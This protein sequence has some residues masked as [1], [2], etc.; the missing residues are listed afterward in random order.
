MMRISRSRFLSSLLSCSL[1]TCLTSFA[2]DPAPP[3]SIT[4]PKKES[5]HLY[6]LIGQSNMAGRGVVEAVDKKPHE[7]V[8]MFT[9]EQKWAPALDPLHFDKP[10]AGVGLGSTFGRVMA[11]AN[12]GVT[13]GLVPCA[14]GG[15]PLERWQQDKDLYKAALVRIKAAMKD[16]TLKGI[17]WHQGESD[18][19]DLEK[20]KTYAT[21]LAAMVE[22]WRKD[23]DAPNVPF[24]AGELGDFLAE[25]SKDGKPVHWKL[26]NEQIAQIPTLVKNAAVVDSSGLKHKGDVVHFDSASLRELGKRYAKAMQ[27]LQ[28][29]RSK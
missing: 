5:L 19:G 21:R 9:K 14:V 26:V 23:L 13:I 10:I 8:V 28:A 1:L 27:E 12:P 16:G 20:S 17:L 25:T 18:S 4:L 22:A 3:A 15:T 29:G 11:D 2:A 24:V 6:L 7:R